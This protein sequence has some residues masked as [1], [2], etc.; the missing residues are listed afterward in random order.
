MNYKETLEYIKKLNRFG[1]KK[2]LQRI[3]TILKKLGNP[4]KNLKI[5]H[6]AGTNGKGSTASYIS[7]ILMHQ[8]YK[9]GL[10]TSPSLEK[11]TD[12]V[13]INGE[14]ISEED[15]SR[16]LTSIKELSEED[17]DMECPTEFEVIT[18]AAYKYFDENNVDFAVIEVGMGGRLDTTNV[19]NPILSVITSISYDHMQ[20]LGNTLAKI[21]YEKAGIIKENVPVVT[22]PQKK[23]AEAVIEKTAHDKNSKFIKVPL[24]CIKFKG[25]RGEFQTFDVSAYGKT[26]YIEDPLFGTFQ[27]MNCAEAVYASF[28]LMKQGIMINDES[29]INGIKDVKWPARMEIMRKDP[30]VILDGA[31]NIDGIYNLFSSIRKYFKYNN[32]ILILGI[33]ADKE[34]EKW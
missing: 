20:I 33:L 1:K 8:G 27:M 21:A 15:V 18:A 34:V 16:L 14:R 19:I 4:E 7:S 23:E 31:H 5:I 25:I 17:E 3:K 32:I 22:C 6:I 30:L 12:R 11:F 29:I 24:D 13:R 28:E 9:V 26:F 2:G 10:Y